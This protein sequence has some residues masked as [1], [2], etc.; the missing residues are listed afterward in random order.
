MTLHERDDVTVLRAA[1]QIAF[2]MTGNGSVF[3]VRGTLSD[4]DSIGDLSALLPLCIG[5]DRSP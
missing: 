1:E 4:R 3:D 2:P 5:L